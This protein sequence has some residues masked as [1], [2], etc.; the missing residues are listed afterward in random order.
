MSV[1]ANLKPVEVF[2]YFEEICSIPH[3]SGNVG[4]LADYCVNFAKKQGLRFVRDN[5][6]NVIIY[7]NATCDSLEPVI[8]QGHLDMVCQKTEDCEIDFERDGL[9]I[10]VDGNIVTAKGTTLGADN[11]IAVAM[12]LA[13]LSSRDLKHPTIEA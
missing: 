9:E 13:I 6:D 11:G 8:L 1:L 4:R 12:I 3:G 7:K 2:K 5:A 10:Y